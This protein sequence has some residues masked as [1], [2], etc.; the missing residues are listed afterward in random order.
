MLATAP[1]AVTLRAVRSHQPRAVYTFETPLA[2][3]RI[4]MEGTMPIRL[5]ARRRMSCAIETSAHVTLAAKL[6]SRLSVD[7][8]GASA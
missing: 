2:T 6:T 5:L 4:G 3:N 7:G 8:A 1:G